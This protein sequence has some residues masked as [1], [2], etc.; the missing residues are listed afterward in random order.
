MLKDLSKRL[1]E[2]ELTLSHRQGQGITSQ[3]RF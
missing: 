2:S 1:E 3:G